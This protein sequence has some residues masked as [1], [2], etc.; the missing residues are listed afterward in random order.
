MKAGCKRHLRTGGASC[1][2]LML[3]RVQYRK[4]RRDLTLCV[5]CT[6]VYERELRRVA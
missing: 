2:R 3:W 1:L 4:L 5:V 6:A